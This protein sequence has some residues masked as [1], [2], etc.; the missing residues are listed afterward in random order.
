MIE[1]KTAFPT[2][3]ALSAGLETLLSA[4]GTPVAQAGVLPGATVSL[5]L[6]ASCSDPSAPGNGMAWVRLR[7]EAPS[8]SF[9]TA[10]TGVN[11]AGNLR[12]TAPMFEVGVAR[13][14]PA[15][16]GT[17]RS[18]P[19]ML[20]YTEAARLQ[21]ADKASILAVICA[22]LDDLELDFVVG[23]YEPIGPD[24]TCVGGAWPVT[25]EGRF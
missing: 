1:D 4:R 14:I 17:T 19:T 21:M 20:T 18:A 23:A 7:T 25:V 9:P 24:A 5:E 15:L 11:N 16:A 2:A 12:A 3:V 8:L 22:V 6:C 10:D 13:C